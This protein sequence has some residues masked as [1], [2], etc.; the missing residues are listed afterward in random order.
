MKKFWSCEFIRAEAARE[1]W[2]GW[3]HIAGRKISHGRLMSTQRSRNLKIESQRKDKGKTSENQHA[4]AV[5]EE[6]VSFAYSVVVR[7]QDEF[8]SGKGTDQHEQGGLGKMEVRQK[9][10]DDAELISGTEEDG[11]LAG[12]RM[13]AYSR[14]RFKAALFGY[15]SAVLQ[16]AGGR[17]SGSDDA[18]LFAERLVDRLGGSRGQ[19]VVLG[20]EVDI[21][22]IFSADR[23]E[24]PKTDVECDG[25]DLNAVR[26]ELIEDLRSEMKSRSRSRGRAGLVRK[27]CLIPFAIRLGIVAVDVGRQGHVADAIQDGAEIIGRGEAQGAFPVVSSIGHLRFKQG[28]SVPKSR[29]VEPFAR[30]YLAPG[31]NECRPL[32]R[33][34]LLRQENFD[35]SCGVWRACLRELTSCTSRIEPSRDDSAVVEDQQIAR[36]KKLRQIAKEVVA[37]LA[38]RAI[39]NEHTARATDRRRRLRDELFRK[40]EMELGY[41]H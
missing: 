10:A 15:L 32:M 39:E 20:V 2:S 8:S 36:M 25:F 28:S 31:A 1:N 17:G 4:I 9:A 30:L 29:E 27:D 18:A 14:V 26:T 35:T 16:C 11:G 22:D 7:G 37:I 13:K 34:H 21:F 38:C 19:R 5:G 3:R 6:A 23:L 41:A 40:I 33:T 24:G 12:V